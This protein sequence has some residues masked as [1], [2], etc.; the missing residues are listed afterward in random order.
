[1]FRNTGRTGTALVGG[2]TSSVA[3]G[4]EQLDERAYR[5]AISTDRQT[6]ILNAA[7]YMGDVCRLGLRFSDVPIAAQELARAAGDV[8]PYLRDT[9]VE[10][11]TDSLGGDDR[12]KLRNIKYELALLSFLVAAVRD[13]GVAKDLAASV[14]PATLIERTEEALA[15]SRPFHERVESVRGFLA[16]CSRLIK[17]VGPTILA[18]PQRGALGLAAF[19]E[20]LVKTASF[21]K[22][23]R[24][25]VI[26]K[27]WK[28]LEE[29]LQRSVPS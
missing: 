10:M 6:H 27:A 8:L 13:D 16:D 19:D 4:F 15:A 29:A 12:R 18:H 2:H 14:L 5:S 23:E 20:V 21:A 24:S 22:T 1:M 25:G 26:A 28:K 9:V 3:S 17:M 11:T 7:S